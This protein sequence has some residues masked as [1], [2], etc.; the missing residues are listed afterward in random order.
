MTIPYL[1][2]KVLT[3]FIFILGHLTLPEKTKRINL[4]TKLH[5]A[6]I[7]KVIRHESW[8]FKHSKNHKHKNCFFNPFLSSYVFSFFFFAVFIAS[9]L[10]SA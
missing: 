2:R 10:S 8:A 1:E 4:S 5:F 6:S 7:E 9:Q 3:C